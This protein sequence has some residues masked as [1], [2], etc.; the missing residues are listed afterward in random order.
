MKGQV[1]LTLG[2]ILALVG[3]LFYFFMFGFVTMNRPVWTMEELEKDYKVDTVEEVHGTQTVLVLESYFFKSVDKGSIIYVR[4]TV[5]EVE[6]NSEVGKTVVWF[7]STGAGRINDWSDLSDGSALSLDKPTS[8]NQSR[9]LQP[10][11]FFEG[12]M[13]STL[14]K[15]AEIGLRINVAGSTNAREYIKQQGEPGADEDAGFTEEDIIDISLYSLLGMVMMIAGGALAGVGAFLTFVKKEGAKA[16]AGAVATEQPTRQ[17]A[18]GAPVRQTKCPACG[19][20]ISIPPG[21]TSIKC[22]SCHRSYQIGGSAAG[23]PAAPAGAPA[24]AQ[25]PATPPA[26]GVR[27]TKCPGCGSAITIPPGATTIRCGSCGRSYNIGGAAPRAPAAAQRPAAAPA[28]GARQAKCPACGSAISIP[29]GATTIACPSCR[30][31]FK[32]G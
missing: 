8:G 23:R 31:S 3:M 13:R 21:A 9:G 7:E 15:G 12:D 20:L 24:A 25:R 18:S 22:G 17:V 28:A 26:G 19:S 6:Y 1:L 14:K 16:P 27:Q 5:E 11:L 4:D 32:V 10:F 29:A 30:R 2:I